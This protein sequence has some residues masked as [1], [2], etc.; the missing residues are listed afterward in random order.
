MR[1]EVF[2]TARFLDH[3]DYNPHG[4]GTHIVLGDGPPAVVPHGGPG[5]FAAKPI[6]VER[7]TA[8]NVRRA[9]GDEEAISRSWHVAELDDA[10]TP[11][12]LAAAPADLTRML[13]ELGLGYNPAPTARREL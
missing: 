5:Q 2:L 13:R 6:P 8:V 11:V 4:F 7:L 3:T 10:G 9:R 1:G 12:R